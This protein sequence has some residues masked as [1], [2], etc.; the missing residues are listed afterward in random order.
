MQIR[1]CITRGFQRLLGNKAF[2]LITVLGNL[3]ISLVL[4]S[5][6]Y[7]LPSDTSSITSRG[8]LIYFA[9]L[10]N[11]LNSALEVRLFPF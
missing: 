4:G 6:F 8:T 2:F 1:L 9:I 10:F 3:V 11:A 5:V 7:D